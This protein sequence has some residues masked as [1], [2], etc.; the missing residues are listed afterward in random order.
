MQSL[1]A[2]F[3]LLYTI[4]AKDYFV[5]ATT[6]CEHFTPSPRGVQINKV[7]L[8]I[9]HPYQ[10]RMVLKPKSK[11]LASISHQHRLCGFVLFLWLLDSLV[12][13]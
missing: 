7:R 8:Y 13:S 10:V 9:A 1:K 11:L 3:L 12:N 4:F 2:Q 5:K 6:L